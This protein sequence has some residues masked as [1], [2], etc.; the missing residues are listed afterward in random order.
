MGLASNRGGDCEDWALFFKASYN[1]LKED[2]REKSIISAAP[3]L[4]DFR[5]YDD[6]Y[7]PDAVEKEVGTTEDKVYVICY[8]SHCVVAVSSEEI[9]NSSDVQKLEGAYAVECQ[10]GKYLFRIGSIGAPK[11]CSPEICPPSNYTYPD[12]WLVI[13]DEDIYDFHYAGEWTGYRDYSSKA[14]IYREQVEAIRQMI[15]EKAV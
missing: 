2:E 9:K 11:I 15:G 10:N 4:G 7:Y 8:D 3:G 1:Y 14:G 13:T 12:I 6:F 5:I